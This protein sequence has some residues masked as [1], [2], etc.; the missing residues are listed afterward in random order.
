MS[1][2]VFSLWFRVMINILVSLNKMLML[3]YLALRDMYVLVLTH[4]LCLVSSSKIYRL[5]ILLF[6]DFYQ[7]G[8][9]STAIQFIVLE[10][11]IKP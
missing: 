2:N 11:C 8:P 1:H 7:N 6:P 3:L 10:T 5:M 9:G 4:S